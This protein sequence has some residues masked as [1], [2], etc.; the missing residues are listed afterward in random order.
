[1]FNNQIYDIITGEIPGQ[2]GPMTRKKSAL[3]VRSKMIGVLLRGTRLNAGRSLKECAVVL[4]RSPHTVSQYEFGRKGISLP[5]LELLARYFEV[6]VNYFWE[7]ESAVSTRADDL[8]AAENLIPLR[9]KIIGVLLRQARTGAGK[10][11]KEC[12]R[13]LGVSADTISKYEHG[14]SPVPFPQLELLS[15]LLDVPLSEFLD[16]GLPTSRVT[17]PGRGADL[18]SPE[19]AWTS[20]PSE[21]QGFIRTPDSLPYLQAALN[22]YA[23]PRDP[24]KRLAKAMLA[25]EE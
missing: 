11:Q 16:P 17:I 24:L 2:G 4:G 21:L 15:S 3:D 20:L 18:L 1:L 5:E 22:L 8:P 19:D 10:T 6:P 14:K 12:A 7:E 13:A 9:Q 23:L 25:V